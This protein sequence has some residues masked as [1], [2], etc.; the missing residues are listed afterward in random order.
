MISLKSAAPAL[1]ISLLAFSPA[2]ALP[3]APSANVTADSGVILAQHHS[4]NHRG[5]R[6]HRPPVVHPRYTP[7]HRY[8]RAPHG[9]RRYSARPG[10]WRTRGCILVGVVWFCP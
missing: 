4:R 8:S 6:A 7:G 5:P 1:L 2:S 3:S 10:D 9:W